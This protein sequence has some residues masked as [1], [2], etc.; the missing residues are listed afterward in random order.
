M[1]L[2]IGYWGHFSSIVKADNINKVEYF[3]FEKDKCPNKLLN[4]VKKNDCKYY[5]IESKSDMWRILRKNVIPDLTIVGNFGFIF[6]KKMIELLKRR[7]INIHP[8]EL[9]EYR[10]KHP[11][12]QAIL[13]GE[14]EM[15]ITAHVLN[16]KIDFGCIIEKEK[17]KINYDESYKYNENRIFELVPD[18]FDNLINKFK[19]NKIKFKN[20]EMREGTYYEPL[21]RNQLEK[22]TNCNKLRRINN[23]G[24]ISN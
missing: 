4:Y 16:E 6:T 23:N 17:L 19:K 20:Q 1:F 2:K 9:P 22:I 10:G 13:N 5:F 18:I 7:I 15:G 8:G 24:K 3:V 11:L 21:E 14:E 12:P